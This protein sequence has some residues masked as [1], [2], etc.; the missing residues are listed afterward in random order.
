MDLQLYIE[1]LDLDELVELR[2]VISQRIYVLTKSVFPITMVLT[3]HKSRG[4]RSCWLALVEVKG[5]IVRNK[6]YLDAVSKQYE[7]SIMT[8][9]FE[10]QQEGAYEFCEEGGR[11]DRRGIFR[12]LPSSASTSQPS[13]RYAAPPCF[14]K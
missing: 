14:S 10:I 9:V 8:A 2:E 7:G 13:D 11:D 5:D 6:K 3:K 12:V 1:E 4:S